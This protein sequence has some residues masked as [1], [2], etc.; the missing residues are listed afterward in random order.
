MYPR[1]AATPPRIAI[2]A[3][4]QT[5]DGAVQSAGVTVVVRPEGGTETGSAGVVSYGVS[6]SVVY[7]APTQAETNYTAFVVTAYKTGCVP[8]SVTVV[9]S[10]A[11]VAGQAALQTATQ[12]SIDAIEADTN[13]LQTNQGAWATAVGFA[14]PTNIT[15]GTITTVT[16]LTNLPAGVQTSID[17]VQAIAA[18][19]VTGAG[20][21]TEVFV[22][23][24]ATVTVTADSSGNRSAVVVT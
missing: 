10:A 14:T 24:N 17:T 15:A 9:T 6:S 16:N 18:G 23:T 13:D 19:T 21:A 12:A 7:Y 2:G 3:V 4:I 1:N 5:S 20:T 8:V 11:S 22:G